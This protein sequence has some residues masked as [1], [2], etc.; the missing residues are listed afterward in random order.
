MKNTINYIALLFGVFFFWSCEDVIDI[1]LPTSD[2]VVVIDAWI[3]DKPETQ[4]IKV[5]KTLPYF[6]NSFLPGLNEATVRVQDLTDN[7]VYDFSRGEEDGT[8]IWEPDITR[9]TFGKIGNDFK[10]TVQ[11]GT[12][13]YEAYSSMNRVPQIDSI[14]YRFE[15]GNSFFPDSYFAQFYALDPIDPGD[16]YWIKAWKNGKFLNQPSEINISYDA[17]GSPGAIVD[18][19]IFIQPIRDGINP[20]DEDENNEFLSPYEPGDS[21]Y[22][23][24]HSINYDSYT[25]LNEV[26]I[27]TNRP[28]GFAELFAQPLA[29]VSSNISLN[30]E[31]SGASNAIGFFNVSAVSAQGR[32]L[33][34]DNLPPKED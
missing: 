17:G 7:V 6:E 2:P 4:T 3:T 28:G 19:I 29:N 8:Y 32:R 14:V 22:V 27:Q 24:L 33:D 34:P 20:F 15:K 13:S 18:G 21:V 11:M 31:T 25:F 9:P 10:L 16:T 26:A 12:I 5:L 23:E 1:E 30:D